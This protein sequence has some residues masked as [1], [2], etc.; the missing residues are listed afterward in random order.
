MRKFIGVGIIV[1]GIIMVIAGLEASDSLASRFS[2]LF[3]GS[4]TDRTLWYFILGVVGLAIG[5]SMVGPRR[6]QT[7]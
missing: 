3:T 5:A 6:R 1:L 7:T 4:P 2:R